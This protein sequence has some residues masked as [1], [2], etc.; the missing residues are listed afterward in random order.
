MYDPTPDVDDDVIDSRD[1]IQRIANLIDAIDEIDQDDEDNPGEREDLVREL[2]QM[3][4]L[5]DAAE[6]NTD[7]WDDGATM[8]RES[9]WVDYVREMCHDCG[10]FDNRGHGPNTRYSNGSIGPDWNA[11]P[12][13]H[14]DWEGVAEEL[15]ST[16]YCTFEWEGVTWYIR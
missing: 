4:A 10:Y 13:K 16:D 6:P 5:R 12:Y 11:W 8:V 2:E 14:I 9:Y 15:G 7:E 1:V 3:Q